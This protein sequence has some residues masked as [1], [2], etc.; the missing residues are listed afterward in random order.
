MI[1]DR[2]LAYWRVFCLLTNVFNVHWLFSTLSNVTVVFLRRSGPSIAGRMFL[3][4]L[5]ECRSLIW[6]CIHAVCLSGPPILFQLVSKSTGLALVTST[7]SSTRSSSWLTLLTIISKSRTLR[8]TLGPSTFFTREAGA[9]GHF[10]C[11]SDYICFIVVE[12]SF[13]AGLR[14]FR[15]WASTALVEWP[16]FSF[17]EQWSICL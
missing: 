8:P 5:S 15:I 10:F 14:N 12:D 9:S 3:S 4:I 6:S 7:T 11:S 17:A 1:K 16:R 2:D 13:T